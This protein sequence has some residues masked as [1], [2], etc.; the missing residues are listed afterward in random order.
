MLEKHLIMGTAGHV[1]HGKTSLIRALTGF[2]CD[3]HKEE[4][5][6]GITINLGFT[7]LN[8][9]D[10][11]SIGIVDVPGHAD[12]IKT[13]VS[14]ACG[15]DLVLMVIA[16]DEGIMP[17]TREHLLIMDQ[18]EIKQGLIALTKIDL[19]DED[20]QDLAKEEIAEFTRNSFLQD[21]PVIP[22]SI[23]NN[24]GV[25]QLIEAISNLTADTP[26]RKS[27]GHFRM[28]I[29]RIFSQPGFG[30]IV[31]GSILSGE[32]SRQE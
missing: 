4:K 13:M 21:C 24:V 26:E 20:L 3:T 5:Q 1:D 10:G 22:V 11:N 29:D 32:I 6:R 27:R 16:A 7:H 18:L 30:T 12:F 8:L 19:V 2:D 9:P 23:M 31:N 15:L 28:Y 25:A 17:Q 14:G